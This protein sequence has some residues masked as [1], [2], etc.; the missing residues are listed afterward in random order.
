[1]SSTPSSESKPSIL[2]RLKPNISSAR[3]EGTKQ[4]IIN[5]ILCGVL[6][7]GILGFAYQNFIVNPLDT[8]EVRIKLE[9]YFDNPLSK[10]KFYFYVIDGP[11]EKMELTETEA[12]LYEGIIKV[13]RKHVEVYIMPEKDR[14]EEGGGT[15]FITR[16]NRNLLQTT[17]RLQLN[18][19]SRTFKKSLEIDKLL[20]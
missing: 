6:L 19:R 8:I 13:R 11:T 14:Y 1:M 9:D 20:F 12:G 2:S 15:S 7:S 18:A 16:G 4:G 17:I 3:K 10:A 5:Y